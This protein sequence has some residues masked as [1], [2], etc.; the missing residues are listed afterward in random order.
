MRCILAVLAVLAAGPAQ[1]AEPG[2]T[3]L[4]LSGTG[5]VREIPDLLV[6]ELSGEADG[7]DPAVA[8]R[9]LD[10]RMREATRLAAGAQGVAWQV[11]GYAV[12]RTMP[13]QKGA[14]PVWTARQTLHLEAVDADTLLGLVGRLQAGGLTVASLEWTLSPGHLADAQEKASDAAL[15]AVKSR[16]SSAAAVLG[17]KVGTIRDVTLGE[18]DRP[19]PMMRMMSA[20]A[21]PQATRAAAEI[22]ETASAEVALVP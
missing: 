3:L 14:R 20:I 22:S 19:R 9:Q 10:Q 11:A 6:A 5:T 4:H 16:A 18:I 7:A 15:R 13:D 1:G 17:L 21:E 2:V 12:D 8:Q